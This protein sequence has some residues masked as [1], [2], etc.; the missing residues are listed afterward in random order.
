MCVQCMKCCFADRRGGKRARQAPAAARCR[1]GGQAEGSPSGQGLTT[2]LPDSIHTFQHR[3]LDCLYSTVH[4][5][6][7]TPATR[8]PPT[9]YHNA[10]PN[11]WAPTGRLQIAKLNKKQNENR[12]MS[13]KS[14]CPCVRPKKSPQYTAAISRDTAVN[15]YWLTATGNISV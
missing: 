14:I 11:D 6:S 12:P 1:P 15:V 10:S 8:R 2:Y 4:A 3:L 7:L 9:V 5:P 13:D